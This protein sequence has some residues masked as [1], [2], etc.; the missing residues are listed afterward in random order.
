MES[1]QVPK[2]IQILELKEYK[3]KIAELGAKVLYFD[4]ITVGGRSTIAG[5]SDS[6]DQD[7]VYLPK[8]VLEHIISM[9][10]TGE[11]WSSK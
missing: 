3:E 1:K 9:N 10:N 4:A 8:V 5:F 6:D 11:D 2:L 7:T